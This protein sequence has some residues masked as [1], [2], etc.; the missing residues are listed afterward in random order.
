MDAENP[1]CC[2]KVQAF[3]LVE[4]RLSIPCVS[5]TCGPFGLISRR[6]GRLFFQSQKRMYQLHFLRFK[7]PPDR[8]RRCSHVCD[9]SWRQ[10]IIS[11]YD[12]SLFV[13]PSDVLSTK[14]STNLELVILPVGDVN[15]VCSRMIRSSVLR[16]ITTCVSQTDE[17]APLPCPVPYRGL[18]GVPWYVSSDMP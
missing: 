8:W 5:S 2:G 17:E 13:K 6:M 4:L 16:R 11:S 3:N 12:E 10:K 14:V 15:S 1:G 18:K 9:I 7:E